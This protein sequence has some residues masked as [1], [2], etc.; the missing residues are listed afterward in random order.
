MAVACKTPL[1]GFSLVLP[2]CP[3]L[4]SV[5]R[6]NWMQEDFD[7]LWHRDELGHGSYSR[8]LQCVQNTTGRTFAVKPLAYSEKALREVALQVRCGPH[9]NIVQIEAVYDNIATLG[10]YDYGMPRRML[11]IVMELCTGGE[12]YQQI[13]RFKR[14]TEKDASRCIQ[15]LATAVAH[16]HS[17]G[18]AHRDIKPENLL[19]KAKSSKLWDFK[20]AD[21]GFAKAGTLATP[22][23]SGFYTAPDV[24]EA[25]KLR[26]DIAAG[27]ARPDVVQQYGMSC[28]LWSVGVVL[29]VLLVG[30]PPFRGT[31]GLTLHRDVELQ[32]TIL[33]GNY[34][35]E[36]RHWDKVSSEAKR[37]VRQ[38][39]EKDAQ[40]R[41]TA[42]LLLEDTWVQGVAAED[43]ELNTPAVLSSMGQDQE[44]H[45][46]QMIKTD[47][48]R[49]RGDNVQGHDLKP[50]EVLSLEECERQLYI[51]RKMF[52]D[53]V[54]I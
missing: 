12:L 25:L 44:K 29:Y 7:V 15:T 17:K 46:K 47:Q 10:P 6:S 21:F 26:Q 8:V 20:L 51:E 52:G 35:V 49:L 11:F 50:I 4:A 37:V 3:E 2:D 48:Q 24:V 31:K 1:D 45:H 18:V 39:L 14:F 32:N 36:G 9:P 22:K 13:K 42:A 54:Y 30:F 19:L 41:L 38:L 28:D 16:C 27:R 33:E 53:G 23:G 34:S 40:Q 5:L 43:R